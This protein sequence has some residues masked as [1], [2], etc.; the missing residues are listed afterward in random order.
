[1]DPDWQDFLRARGLASDAAVDDDG[2]TA[3]ATSAVLCDLS[4]LAVLGFEGADAQASAGFREGG[5]VGR[6]RIR[7]RATRGGRV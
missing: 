7:V 2:L 5:T 6:L 1:M 3:A 4:H